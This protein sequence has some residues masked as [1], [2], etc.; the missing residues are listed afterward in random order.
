MCT[1]P[2]A[3]L[4]LTAASAYSSAKTS[5]ET[6]DYQASVAKNNQKVAE[7]QA[8]DAKARGDVEAA[9]VRRKYAAATGSQRAALAARGL[10]ISDG[11]ASSLMA[12]TAYFGEV[13][14]ATTRANAAREAWGYQVRA[15]NLAGDAAA[16]SAQASAS[17]PLLAAGMS[18]GKSLLG[19]YAGGVSDK[20]NAYTG[21]NDFARVNGSNALD[22]WGRFGSAGD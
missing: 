10:D 18:A 15:N 21:T 22:T 17:N 8:D 19:A 12:D 11:S 5:Q 16:Y 7:Y 6:A 14:G 20:W 3:M 2:L 4:A 13:D 9:N 1:I